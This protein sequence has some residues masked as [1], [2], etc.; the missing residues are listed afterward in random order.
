MV[1]IIATTE[2]VREK[3]N[4]KKDVGKLRKTIWR[5][6]KT[7]VIAPPCNLAYNPYNLLTVY[8]EEMETGY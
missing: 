1:I 6:L 2:K 5:F 8:P 3:K 4:R 7:L